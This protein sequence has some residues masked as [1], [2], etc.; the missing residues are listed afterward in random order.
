MG[1]GGASFADDVDSYDLTKAVET[2]SDVC[3]GDV[4]TESLDQDLFR[5]HDQCPTEAASTVRLGLG[6]R[7]MVKAEMKKMMAMTI[8]K[9]F[10]ASIML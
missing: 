7:A 5:R 9:P 4:G 1:F 8:I 10:V 6:A 2:G 3:L